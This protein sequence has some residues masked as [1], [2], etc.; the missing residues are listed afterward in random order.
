M[1]LHPRAPAAPRGFTLIELLIA[2]VIVSVMVA[3]AFNG[4]RLGITSWDAVSERA[5][6][7]ERMRVVVDLVRRQLEQAR[8][9]AA[10]EA[11]A[12]EIEF[13]GTEDTLSF[14][15]PMP[16]RVALGGMYRLTLEARGYGTRKELVLGYELHQARGW[17]RLSDDLGGEVLLHEDVR[18]VAF[19]YFGSGDDQQT[20]RWHAR[21][22]DAVRLPALIRVRVQERDGREWPE[23]VV[24][25]RSA[26]AGTG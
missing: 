20:P 7:S 18:S 23:L 9:V 8:A 19:A 24:A 3:L 22:E 11:D 16:G 1:A 10:R 14:V 26:F 6:A 5:Q 25:P 13:S 2:T 4:L 21:W 12:R 15:A 17:E